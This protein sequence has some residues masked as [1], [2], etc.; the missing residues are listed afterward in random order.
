MLRAV[1]IP[2]NFYD[3][4]FT[5]ASRVLLQEALSNRLVSGSSSS[6]CDSQLWQQARREG[7]LKTLYHP[8]VHRAH[9]IAS[10]VHSTEPGSGL[11]QS[12]CP[13]EELEH[14][15]IIVAKLGLS[16]EVVAAA[17]LQEAVQHPGLTDALLTQ[18]MPEEVVQLIAGLAQAKTLSG[19]YR[20]HPDLQVEVRSRATLRA[21]A[22]S[23]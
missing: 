16:A 23:P 18:Y 17:L 12:V 8:V 9:V 22:C 11:G 14:T 19:L 4:L 2:R 6:A 7:E 13:L 1:T 21:H 20:Q 10:I 5:H 3:E 15:A